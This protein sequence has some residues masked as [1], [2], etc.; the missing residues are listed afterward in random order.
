MIVDIQVGRLGDHKPGAYQSKEYGD[1]TKYSK[2]INDFIE[3]ENDILKIVLDD[4]QRAR[5]C[6]SAVYQHMYR[7]GYRGADVFMKGNA[8]YLIKRGN[9]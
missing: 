3:D 4:H 5:S 2:V 8:I 9:D 1:Y 7:V 6:R